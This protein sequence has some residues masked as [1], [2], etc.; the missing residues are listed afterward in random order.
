[1]TMTLAIKV[2]NMIKD[3]Y[4]MNWNDARIANHKGIPLTSRRWVYTNP[5]Y[6]I[7]PYLN[8]R[9]TGF[10]IEVSGGKI[11]GSKIE[12]R[13]DSKIV[14][15]SEHRSSDALVVYVGLNSDFDTDQLNPHYI[16]K[17]ERRY[18]ENATFFN[19]DKLDKAVDFIEQE[20]FKIQIEENEDVWKE[21]EELRLN[22]P[23]VKKSKK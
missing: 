22:E 17:S 1:M 2:L 13:A 16:F 21:D 3:N 4:S 14:I 5:Y 23:L 8:G 7:R 9:E 12:E 6:V 10:A 20:L 11:H 15:F 18:R 19:Q